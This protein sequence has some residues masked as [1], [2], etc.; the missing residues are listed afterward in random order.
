MPFA[1]TWMQLEILILSKSERERQIPYHLCVESKIS[2][3]PMNPS[4]EPKKTLRQE[5][6]TCGCQGGQGREWDGLKS[7]VLVDANYY[8]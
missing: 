3:E 2:T 6:Q 4:T 7:S 1:A 5:E 8:F